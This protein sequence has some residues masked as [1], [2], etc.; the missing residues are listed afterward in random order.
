[1]HRF[2]VFKSSLMP[3]FM[4]RVVAYGTFSIAFAPR[5][6]PVT[7]GDL[8][9]FARVFVGSAGPW[10]GAAADPLLGAVPRAVHVR[11]L[12]LTNPV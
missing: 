7:L 8:L 2:L 5:K 6:S 11:R 1:M 10:G 4:K 9:S 3:V 12:H